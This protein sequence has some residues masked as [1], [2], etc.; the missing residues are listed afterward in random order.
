MDKAYNRLYHRMISSLNEISN[1]SFAKSDLIFDD[2]TITNKSYVGS[3][4][5]IFDIYMFIQ[6]TLLPRKNSQLVISSA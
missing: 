6:T 1:D 3:Y 4:K 5:I 2:S